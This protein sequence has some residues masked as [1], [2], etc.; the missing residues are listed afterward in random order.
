M[1]IAVQMLWAIGSVLVFRIMLNRFCVQVESK[2]RLIYAAGMMLTYTAFMMFL[3]YMAGSVM[4]ERMSVHDF[5]I[6]ICILIFSVNIIV[7]FITIVY[8]T[9]ARKRSLSNREKIMLKDL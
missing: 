4:S 3:I 6:Y 5:S 8:C 9:T 2:K 1:S 7:G